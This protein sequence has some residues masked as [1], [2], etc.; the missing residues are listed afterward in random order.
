MPDPSSTTRAPIVSVI[1]PVRNGEELLEL[2]LD[3]LARQ[4]IDR[5][6]FEVVIA[7][8]GSA[9]PP[10]ALSTPDG[11]IRVLPG[12]P[13]NSYAA[14]N[15]GVTASRGAILAFC[16]ADCVPE[17]DWLERGLAALEGADLVA[18]RITF[19]VPEQRTV[20]TLLDMDS[21]KNQ[22]LLVSHG[23]AET[24]NL[25][26]RR[27]RFDAVRGFDDTVTEHGD[28]D[29]AERSVRA[30]AVLRYADDVVVSHPARTTAV[31]VLRAHWIYCRGYAERSTIRHEQV[32]GLKLRN[33][34][35]V[36]NTVRSRRRNGLALTPATAWLA[37]NG[38]HPTRRERL[39]SLPLTYIVL[40][41][42]RN[43]AQVVGA[44]DGRRRRRITSRQLAA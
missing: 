21:S 18:G 42:F 25:F 34:V 4:T 38:V 10:T 41:Y 22:K 11:H 29:F 13:T 6:R 27:D 36:V 5:D 7:D 37:Q 17:P 44:V 2:L 24:A 23:R 15:R 28:F 19:A 14:R 30:G 32:E 20:W 8:D 40:P 1:V 31:S 3:A 16:D 43:I 33:W 26:V 9:E 12:P 35:P 39:L